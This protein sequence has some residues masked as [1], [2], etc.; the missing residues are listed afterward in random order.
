MYL[1]N[2]KPQ[3]KTVYFFYSCKNKKYFAD[4]PTVSVVVPF[5]N[6]HF[7]T[8][9]R[10]AVSLLIRSPPH[11]LLEVILV[12]DFS[13]QG[14]TWNELNDYAIEH[15]KGRIKVIQFTERKGLMAARTAGAKAAKGEV[16]VF[17]DAHT[18]ANVNWLPP[19]VEPIAKNYRICTVPFVDD[20]DVKNYEYR[21]IDNGKRGTFN[22]KFLYKRIPVL[23]EDLL[24][25]SEPFKS[26]IMNGGLFAISA[27]FFWELGGYDEGL[28][29]WGGEQFD[30]S[31]KIWQCH[32]AIYDV[33]CSHFGHLFRYG[34][35]PF[36]NPRS[37]DYY[38]RNLKRVAE[39]WMDEYKEIAYAKDP[40]RFAR[41]NTGDLTKEKAIRERL[42]CKS[43]KWY[44]ENVAIEVLEMFP[45]EGRPVFASGAVL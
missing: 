10:T 4:L 23:P 1:T 25:P 17:L 28:D 19:L 13:D 29:I 16:L 27:K 39:V 30:I 31:F 3:S 2:F 34:G 7:S 5:W 11:L 6:E 15:F 32:G 38:N 33:P 35:K 37:F 8:L 12:N 14:F 22:W 43:F 9:M 26:P 44:L 24:H 21:G 42:Q 45:P 20:V 18:E 36:P 40:E 41:T